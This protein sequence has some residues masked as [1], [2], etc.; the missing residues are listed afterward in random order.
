MVNNE[1]ENVYRLMANADDVDDFV[2][3]IGLEW[4]QRCIIR[5]IYSVRAKWQTSA[6][7]S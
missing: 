2:N 1:P 4:W 5:G 3:L 7:F 6:S